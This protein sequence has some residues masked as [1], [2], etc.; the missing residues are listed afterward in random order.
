[1]PAAPWTSGSTMSAASVGPCSA[2]V[3][4]AS[5]IAAASA[6]SASSPRCQRNTCGGVNR[7]AGPHGVGDESMER[8]GVADADGT[9]RVAVVRLDQRR[10]ARAQ[11]VAAELVVLKGDP[12]RH[13]DGRRA[14]VGIEDARQAGRHDRDERVRQLDGRR[15]REAE[16][17]RVRDAIHLR[18]QCRVERRMAVPVH[19][20]PERRDAVQVAPSVGIDEPAATALDDHERIVGEPFPHL[21]ERVPEVRPVP[22]DRASRVGHRTTPTS[23]AA[24]ANASSARSSCPRVCV[25]I[26]VTRSRAVP[27]ELSAGGSGGR[28]ARGAKRLAERDGTGV[29]ADEDRHDVRVAADVE[30]E[31]LQPAAEIRR[32]VGERAAAI[33]LG[34]DHVEGRAAA[35][36]DAGARPVVK[37][38]LRAR[39]TSTSMSTASR[40]RRPPRC[41]APCRAC[42]SARDASRRRARR[43]GRRRVRRA[44]RLHGPRPP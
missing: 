34:R 26:G 37:M 31:R 36:T 22:R 39:F 14:R 3:R 16:E 21:G 29:L 33:R 20:A 38:K 28:A 1:M 41:R 43:R 35:A 13:L 9:E 6:A 11:R 32:V 24:F 40:R 18:A 23:R 17:R 4:S 44:R 8:L 2:M 12:E 42:P 25:A 27:P 5:S 10:E 19:V 15:A 30:A 7:T